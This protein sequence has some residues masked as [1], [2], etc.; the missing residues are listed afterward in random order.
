MNGI[1]TVDTLGGLQEM[2]MV[3]RSG[4]YKVAFT[5]RKPEI[6]VLPSLPKFGATSMWP[7]IMYRIKNCRLG[8][9][10]LVLPRLSLDLGDHFG[11]LGDC[12]G[13]V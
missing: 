10:V 11:V 4:V 3:S 8:G 12:S 1:R 13:L 7:P 6:D 9:D 2:I 5:S